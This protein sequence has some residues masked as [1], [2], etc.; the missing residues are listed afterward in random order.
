MLRDLT[1]IFSV[2]LSTVSV[3]F[4]LYKHIEA[5][6][7]KG[8]AYEQ[9]Y[10]IV[11]TIQQANIGSSAKAN[12]SSA[13]LRQI[14]Q[15]PPVI[16]LSRS[17]ADE[18]SVPSTCTDVQQSACRELAQQLGAVNDAC[19]KAAD[20]VCVAA[21]PLTNAVTEQGCTSCFDR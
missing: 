6:N 20:T 2:L 4:G 1:M 19:R 21:V 17:S 13:A 9:A 10:R 15:P 18:P 5:G 11:D 12:L 7:A 8:F 14:G 16:D 3:I